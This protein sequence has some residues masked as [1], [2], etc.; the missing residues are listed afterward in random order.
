MK[1]VA[2]SLTELGMTVASWVL[3]KLSHDRRHSLPPIL[4]LSVWPLLNVLPHNLSLAR[5][6][7]MY[8]AESKDCY[9]Y[10]NKY[11]GCQV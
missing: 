9:T 6:P 5:H 3:F 7:G 8:A 2:E 1:F 4:L 10:L 11:G